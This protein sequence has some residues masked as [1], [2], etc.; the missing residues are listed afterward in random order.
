[1]KKEILIV[2]I[3]LLAGVFSAQ[4]FGSEYF[5]TYGFLNEYHLQSFSNVKLDWVALFWNVF[6]ERGKLFLMIV[7]LGM[8]PVKRALPLLFRAVF[9]YTVGLYGAACVMN[10]GAA[11]LGVLF[12]SVFPHG[13]FYLMVLYLF[14]RMEG[15]A[16]YKEHKHIFTTAF[17]IAVLLVLFLVGCLLETTIGT[18]LLQMYLRKIVS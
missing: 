8:T 1:M 3:L 4:L 5:A 6:W 17:S 16:H 2:V 15:K 12:F 11:G 18:C 10:M 9:G 7:I 14:L 13:I